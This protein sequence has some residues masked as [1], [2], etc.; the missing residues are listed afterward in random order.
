VK[1]HCPGC[2]KVITDAGEACAIEMIA[3]IVIG[4]EN[5]SK[6]DVLSYLKTVNGASWYEGNIGPIADKFED[7]VSEMIA[8]STSPEDEHLAGKPS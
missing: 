6:H 4:R 7:A 1:I 2:R 3:A 8:A 5:V